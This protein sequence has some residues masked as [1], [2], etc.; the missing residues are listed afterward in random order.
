MAR[1]PHDCVAA[2]IE[3]L[4]IPVVYLTEAEAGSDHQVPSAL[5]FIWQAVLAAAPTSL[6]T[7]CMII[8]YNA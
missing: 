1:L 4:G 7:L 6:L 3:S 2:Q 8:V 5:P